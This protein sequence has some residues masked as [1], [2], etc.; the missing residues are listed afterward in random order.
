[1]FWGLQVIAL[2]EE[3]LETAKE[4]EKSGFDIGA[5]PEISPTLLHAG[6]TYQHNMV[7]IL[8]S[9]ERIVLFTLRAR[10]VLVLGKELAF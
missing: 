10:L 6:D 4:N 7:N 5:S 9:M 8:L 3:L 2:T 1:M